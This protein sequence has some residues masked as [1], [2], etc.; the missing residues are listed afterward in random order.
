MQS[1]EE[2]HFVVVKL[3]DGEDLFESIGKVVEKHNISS[4]I[5]LGGV[6]MLRDFEI[7]YWGGKEY[8][9][10]FHETPHELIHLGGSIAHVDGKFMPHIHCAVAGPDHSLKGGHLNRAKVAVL[11]EITIL[12]LHDFYLT[13]KLNPTSGLMELEV[14]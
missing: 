10:E 5:F 8:L 12:K 2:R 3:N 14:M 4:G 6:G 13:R 11:N 1:A 9:T 7:G